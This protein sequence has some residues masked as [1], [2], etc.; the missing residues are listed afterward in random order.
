MLFDLLKVLHILSASLLLMSLFYSF[1]RWIYLKNTKETV[2]TIQQQT[3][4]II[5]PF[6]IFQLIT[7]FTMISLKQYNLSEFWVVGSVAGFITMVCCWFI[8]LYF[9]LSSQTVGFFK[10]VQSFMILLC[11]LSL[12][13]MIFLMANKIA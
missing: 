9:L 13:C 7:G 3:W 2:I 1:Y 4:T 5:I 12:F 8:F 10:G 6:S 11:S